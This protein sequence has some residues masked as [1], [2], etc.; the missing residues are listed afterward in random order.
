MFEFC[1]FPNEFILIW[2]IL[3]LIW[4][5]WINIYHYFNQFAAVIRNNHF[6]KVLVDTLSFLILFVLAKSNIV[7]D[8]A[9]LEIV[10]ISHNELPLRVSLD[11][12]VNEDHGVQTILVALTI[13]Y[14]HDDKLLI[15]VFGLC[16]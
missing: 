1:H 4:L 10:R 6:R 5:L 12:F 9:R 15:L 13:V 8:L 14:T 7:D 3:R 16:F 2:I 11:F